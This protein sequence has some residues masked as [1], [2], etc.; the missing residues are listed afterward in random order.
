MR[1]KIHAK[2]TQPCHAPP[3]KYIYFTESIETP[4]VV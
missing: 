4:G 3:T 2:H 1:E